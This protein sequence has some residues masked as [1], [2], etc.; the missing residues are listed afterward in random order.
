MNN[1]QFYEYIRQLHLFVEAQDKRIKQL[2]QKVHEL[3]DDIQGLKNKPSI[4]VDK[5]EYKFDQLKV[6]TLEGTLNIGLNPSDMQGIE[7]FAVEGKQVVNN[8]FSPADRFQTTISIQEDILKDLESDVKTIIQQYEQENGV[9]I[10]ESYVV[11]INDDIKKQLAQRIEFYMN[12]IPMDQRSSEHPDAYVTR[13]SD[14][15]KNDIHN[16]IQVF[17]K[18][19]PTDMKGSK[20]T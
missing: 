11:F 15:I 10:D 3:D 13:I 7:D 12:Q 4:R 1:H 17:L 2:E 14:T 18:N 20:D 8:P 16:G 9:H 19:L 5:I 6:E